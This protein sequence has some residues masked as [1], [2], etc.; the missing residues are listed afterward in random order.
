MPLHNLFRFEEVWGCRF[1]GAL[2]VH[3][4]LQL[5]NG[6]EVVKAGEHAGAKPGRVV[7]RSR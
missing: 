2:L 5:V 7:R 6:V 4:N 3:Y 1:L